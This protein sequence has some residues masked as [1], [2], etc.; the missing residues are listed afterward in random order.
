ME[1]IEAI[2]FDMDG[3]ILDTETMVD[4]TWLIAAQEYNLPDIEKAMIECLGTNKNDTLDILNKRYG[5]ICN[6]ADFMARTSILF[7]KLEDEEGIQLMPFAN[8]CLEYLK[9]KYRIALASSTRK[10]LVLKQLKNANVLDYFEVIITGDMVFHSKPSPEIYIKA[11]EELNVLPQNCIAIEDSPNG[12]KSAYNAGL[13]TIM[14][15]DKIQ[16]NEEIMPFIWKTCESL[17][18]VMDML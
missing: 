17:K 9:T 6:P 8:E 16:P 4:K 2:I 3:V 5:H 10:E 13:K 11:C 12:L 14:V 15:P 18:I 7:H 1:N